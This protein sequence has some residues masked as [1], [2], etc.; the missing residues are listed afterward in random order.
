MSA[1]DADHWTQSPTSA[2][3]GLGAGTDQQM[4][5]SRQSHPLLVPL[6]GR[7]APQPAGERGSWG[8]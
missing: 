6:K 7:V 5:Q 8:R 3:R 4:R 2:K 1:S